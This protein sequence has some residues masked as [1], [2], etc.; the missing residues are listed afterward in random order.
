M[1]KPTKSKFGVDECVGCRKIH[2]GLGEQI[3]RPK[4]GPN[5]N[6]FAAY[7]SAKCVQA[8][9]V[10]MFVD[11]GSTTLVYPRSLMT[12]TAAFDTRLNDKPDAYLSHFNEA[13]KNV[14]AHSSDPRRLS[15][16]VHILGLFILDNLRQVVQVYAFFVSRKS[17]VFLF[18]S[19]ED[20]GDEQSDAQKLSRSS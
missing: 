4:S 11:V 17:F 5:S 13:N 18:G 2:Q 19:L 9:Y 1:A 15:V 8:K 7:G 10:S 12:V 20:I 3:L 6:M 16:K 14:A